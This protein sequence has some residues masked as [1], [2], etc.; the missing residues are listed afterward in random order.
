MTNK[1][2]W[3]NACWFLFHTAAAKLKETDVNLIRPLLDIILYICRHLPCPICSEHAISSF[4]LLRAEKID[5]KEALINCLLQFHNSVNART[6]KKQFTRLECDNKYSNMF[7]VRI[8][9]IWANIMGRNM[10]GRNM[11]YTMSRNKMIV[12]VKKFF[13]ENH[14]SFS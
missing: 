13:I 12:D 1:T 11:L 4:K 6:G 3:G 2:E 8:F 7:T 14:L 9:N 10:P 5:S